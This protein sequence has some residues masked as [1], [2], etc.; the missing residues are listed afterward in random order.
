[1][2]SQ[3]NLA[4]PV[5]KI[6]LVGTGGTIAGLQETGLQAASVLAY[7]A[8]QVPIQAL[9]E[10]A[11]SP[12]MA[13]VV[14]EQLAQVDSKNMRFALWEKLYARLDAAMHD[15][16]IAAIVITHGTDTMEETAYFLHATLVATKPVILTGAMR[17]ANAQDSD[18][19]RNL[20]EALHQATQLSSGIWVSFAAKIFPALTVQKIHA[21]RLDA[22]DTI[23]WLDTHD[24]RFKLEAPVARWPRVEIVMNYAGA[25]GAIVN[26]LVA[27][28]VDGIVVAGTGNA[29]ISDG[30][31]AALVLASKAGIAV[32]LCSR[33]LKGGAVKS[34]DHAFDVSP[35]SAAKARIALMLEWMQAK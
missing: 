34:T 14:C 8:G 21:T 17:P 32:S 26:A 35:L 18:G 13:D 3:E 22:F 29:T 9:L 4:N 6:L 31:Q 27:Q 16:E 15:D 20:R 7:R 2:N 5:Q 30:L 10:A 28:K 33:C 11:Q 25:D 23:E 12:F 19:A 24:P 1:M